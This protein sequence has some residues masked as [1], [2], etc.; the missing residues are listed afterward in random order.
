MRMHLKRPYRLSLL[1]KRVEEL[2]LP[3]LRK[4]EGFKDDMLCGNEEGSEAVSISWWDW[5]EDAENYNRKFYPGVLDSLTSLLAG[6]PRVKTYEIMTST[7]RFGA[8]AAIALIR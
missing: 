4:Q 2:V 6:I 3:V 7:R 8:R 5:E 1:Q